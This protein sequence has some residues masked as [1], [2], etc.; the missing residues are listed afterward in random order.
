VRGRC[1]VR[2]LPVRGDRDTYGEWELFAEYE[3]GAWTG[4]LRLDPGNPE[5][6]GDPDAA[7]VRHDEPDG[8]SYGAVADGESVVLANGE[9]ADLLDG[10]FYAVATSLDPRPSG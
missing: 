4:C 9:Q 6:C 3:D 10:R 5:E 1:T 2:R 7:F 8:L